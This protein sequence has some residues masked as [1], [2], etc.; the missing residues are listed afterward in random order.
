MAS[1]GASLQFLSQC[2]PLGPHHGTPPRD[3]ITGP[4]FGVSPLDPQWDPALRLRALWCRFP[5][6]AEL[7]FPPSTMLEC[8]QHVVRRNKR[9]NMRL[10]EVVPSVSTARADTSGITTVDD[11]PSAKNQ[12]T[13]PDVSDALVQLTLHQKVAPNASAHLASSA[14]LTVN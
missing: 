10:V 9:R 12:S 6:E 2:A 7:L 14:H 1:R 8:K 5:H 13:P 11:A 4:L 3:P